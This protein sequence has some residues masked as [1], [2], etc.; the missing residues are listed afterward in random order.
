MARCYGD[1]SLVVPEGMDI[2][3]RSSTGDV[4]LTGVTGPVTVQS[5]VGDVRLEGAPSEAD[6]RSSVGQVT[7]VLG[8]PASM[9]SVQTAV[10]DIDLT[11]PG[12]V[13]YDV[14]SRSEVSDVVTTVRQDSRSEYVVDVSSNVGTITIDGD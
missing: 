3:V 14:R 13:A 1:F 6:L 9:L 10:G 11:L 8:E 7:A 4:D 12:E 5:S 2:T